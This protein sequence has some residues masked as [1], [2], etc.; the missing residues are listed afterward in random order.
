M[1]RRINRLNGGSRIVLWDSFTDADGTTIQGHAP[2]DGCA[3]V[4]I[5]RGNSQG[6][7]TSNRAA[8][9]LLNGALQVVAI[10]KGR[11][12]RPRGSISCDIV[13]TAAAQNE[14]AG[15]GLANYEALD[16]IYGEFLAT[17]FLRL[18]R[19]VSS[20]EFTVGSAAQ[21]LTQD[22]VYRLKLEVRGGVG[23]LYLDGVLKIRAEH[24]SQ[25]RR[26]GPSI[27]LA[28]QQAV[29]NSMMRLDNFLVER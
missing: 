28:N 8:P 2:D 7:I 1:R 29:N 21:V 19:R 5:A 15:V 11:S 16:A 6:V 12:I 3:M 20:V 9:E 26:G 10:K 13:R 24:G 14:Q 4:P 25:R 23:L 27:R 22:Q 17:G 18:I